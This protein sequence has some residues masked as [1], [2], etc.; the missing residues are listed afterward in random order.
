GYSSQS[1]TFLRRGSS[2]LTVTRYI[3]LL[4]ISTECVAIQRNERRAME[5]L[6][7]GDQGRVTIELGHLRRVEVALVAGEVAVA[8]TPGP[9]RVE[10]EWL[11]GPPVRIFEED[12]V[13]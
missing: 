3:V 9:S 11:G 1:W 5:R 13:L 2:Q 7:S 12:G 10:V 6:V 4:C 8:A